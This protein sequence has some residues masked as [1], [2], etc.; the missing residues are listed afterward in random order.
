MTQAAVESGDVT[1]SSITELLSEFFQA[2]SFASGSAALASLN[3]NGDQQLDANDEAWSKL[4]LW[5]DDGDAISETDEFVA[6]G[7]VLSSIDLGS[8]ETLSEQPNWAAGNAVLRRLSGVNLDDPPSDL[9]LYD[10]GLRVAPAGSAPLPLSVS[11]PLKL[12]ENGNAVSLGLTSSS[13]E[14]QEGQDALTLV[15]LSGLPDELVPSLG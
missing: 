1:I 6:I 3:S 10:I 2:G 4:Q 13:D 7:D 15:R 11:G 12:Q 8:L 14:W 9:A 5:F